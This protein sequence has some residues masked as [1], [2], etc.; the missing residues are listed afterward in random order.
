MSYKFTPDDLARIA[1]RDA[2]NAAAVEKARKHNAAY[3]E[4]C[5]LHKLSGNP[6]PVQAYP[7]FTH[8]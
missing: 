2:V 7:T 5:R 8:R 6:D 4:R 1:E 3:A